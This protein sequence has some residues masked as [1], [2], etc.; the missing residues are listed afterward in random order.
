MSS[1]ITEKTWDEF[2]DTGLLVMIN[3]FLQIF[4]WCIVVEI[5]SGKVTRVFPARTSFRGLA[6]M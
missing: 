4:G 2:R 3:C 6:K 5:E 1:P